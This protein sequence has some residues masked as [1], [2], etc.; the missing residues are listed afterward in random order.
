LFFIQSEDKLPLSFN[1]SEGYNHAVL[2]FRV[3]DAELEELYARMIKHGV[4]LAVDGIVDRGGCGREIAF[5]DPDGRKIE[6]NTYGNLI[7]F[8]PS[9]DLAFMLKC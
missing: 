7:S 4:E 8:E 1:N 2:L 6:L 3:K 5:Y 9:F